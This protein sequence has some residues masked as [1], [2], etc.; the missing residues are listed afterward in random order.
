MKIETIGLYDGKW[1]LAQSDIER[2]YLLY[3]VMKRK[4][5]LYASKDRKLFP[6]HAVEK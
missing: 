6:D 4:I 5:L 3:E 1:T 2:E